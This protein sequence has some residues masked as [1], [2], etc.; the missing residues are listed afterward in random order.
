MKKGGG[1]YSREDIIF[2]RT[3]FKEIRYVLK[4]SRVQ[5][6]VEILMITYPSFQPMRSW[7]NN[8]TQDLPSG[9]EFLT[10][11]VVFESCNLCTY[12]FVL[13]MLKLYFSRLFIHL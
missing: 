6:W 11:R 9:Q 7:D 12:V 8:Y 2:G 5:E 4:I 10:G 3:L 13:R 1:H